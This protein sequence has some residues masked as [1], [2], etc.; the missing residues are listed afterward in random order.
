M[1]LKNFS[2]P[3]MAK[4]MALVRAE[5]GEDAVIVS[6]HVRADGQGVEVIAAIEPR[7]EIEVASLPDEEAAFCADELDVLQDVLDYHRAPARLIEKLYSAARVLETGC[8][9]DAPRRDEHVVR[10]E[11]HGVIPHLPGKARAFIH[12][13]TTEAESA[14]R[15]LDQQQA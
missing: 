6:N 7:S 3:T 9:V 5:L 4:A 1:R 8:F 2:A 14:R 13:P 11:S 15:W 10:P 12:Q